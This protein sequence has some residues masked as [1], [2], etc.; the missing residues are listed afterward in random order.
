MIV[1]FGKLL[2]DESPDAVIAMDLEGCILYWSKGAEVMFGYDGAAVL[3]RSLDELI[4]P[5]EMVEEERRRLTEA[6]EKGL[7]TFESL[8]RK[9]DGSL[10]YVDISSK[11]VRDEGGT[12]Q[13]FLSS[14]KDVSHLKVLRDAKLLEAKYGGLLESTP[15]GIVMV[16]ATGRIV[17]ANRQAERLFSYDHGE[18][19]GK[20]IEVL[21]PERYHRPHIGHRSGYFSQPHTRPMGVGLE[22][23]G[24]CKDGREFPVEISLSPVTTEQ[25][26]MVMSAIRD[27]SGRKKA[28]KKFRDLLESAPDAIVIVNNEGE[29]VLVNSQAEKLFA[30]AREELLGKKIEILVPGRYRNQ[31][32]GHRSQFFKDPNVR[33]MG[34]GLELYGLRK[35]GTEF[36]VEISLSPIETEEGTLVSSAIRDITERKQFERELQE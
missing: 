1:D 33:P 35:D 32:P 23:Y 17:L 14:K 8:R 26:T 30:Y 18:L 2:L 6:I 36:P 3:G 25:G 9:K 24:L 16:N 28:E 31:H 13:F 12:V 5:R 29:I 22:L 10:I 19:V 27:I 20:L 7:C 15:D 11:A 4:V 21:I 34:A